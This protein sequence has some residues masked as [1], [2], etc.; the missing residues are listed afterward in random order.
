MLAQVA[1]PQYLGLPQV[2]CQQNMHKVLLTQPIQKIHL[3]YPQQLSTKRMFRRLK[4]LVLLTWCAMTTTGARCRSSSIITGSSLDREE[5]QDR[6]ARTI[7]TVTDL[8]KEAC[9]SIK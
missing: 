7:I 2:V 6:V 5:C 4:G 9:N 8:C 3:R 1:L